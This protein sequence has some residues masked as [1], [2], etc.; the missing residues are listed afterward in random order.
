MASSSQ[1]EPTCVSVTMQH[2]D[3]F[4]AEIKDDVSKAHPHDPYVKYL[5][6]YTGAEPAEQLPLFRVAID[7]SEI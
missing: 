3:A 6:A 1:A 7:N 2:S 5:R 4:A